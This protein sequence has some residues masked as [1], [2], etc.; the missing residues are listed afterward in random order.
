MSKSTPAPVPVD[1]MQLLKEAFSVRYADLAPTSEQTKYFEQMREVMDV[2]GDAEIRVFPIE[3]D[4]PG[5][6]RCRR[7][8]GSV[9]GLSFR[10]CGVIARMVEVA[11]RNSDVADDADRDRPVAGGA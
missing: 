4:R 1:K 8:D 3:P 2:V 6:C 7:K 10:D 9:V 11:R 5:W